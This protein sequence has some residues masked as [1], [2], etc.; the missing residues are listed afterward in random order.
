MTNKVIFPRD[1][2]PTKLGLGGNEITPPPT[3]TTEFTPNPTSE[4]PNITF[5][6]SSESLSNDEIDKI[7]AMLQEIKQSRMDGDNA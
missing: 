6:F 5:T 4:P 2:D 3:H 7:I 1:F